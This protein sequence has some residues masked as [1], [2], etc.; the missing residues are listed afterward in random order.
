ME[1][2]RLCL[3]NLCSCF[4]LLSYITPIFH[5]LEKYAFVFYTHVNKYFY[6]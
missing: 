5:I 6:K 3:N 1:T 4:Y 2:V